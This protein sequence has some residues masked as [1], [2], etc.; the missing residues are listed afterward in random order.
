MSSVR[1][2]VCANLIHTTHLTNCDLELL[3]A[4]IKDSLCSHIF[5]AANN[6]ANY[7]RLLDEHRISAEKFTIIPHRL[8][9]TRLTHP[10]PDGTTF[11]DV[12][13]PTCSNR[14]AT[15]KSSNILERQKKPTRVLLDQKAVLPETSCGIPVNAADERIDDYMSPPD[16]AQWRIYGARILRNKLCTPFHLA[17]GCDDKASCKFGHDYTGPA[18]KYCLRYAVRKI[19]CR[20]GGACRT[21]HCFMGHTCRNSACKNGQIRSCQ[22]PDIDGKKLGWKMI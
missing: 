19:P 9:D 11:A 4:Y 10:S 22:L 3:R 12:F 17:N 16:Y 1:L 6:S 20:K 15:A 8:L 21:E 13:E 14:T 18:V 7:T 5:L 2:L